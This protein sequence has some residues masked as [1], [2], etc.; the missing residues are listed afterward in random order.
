MRCLLILIGMLIITPVYAQDMQGKSLYEFV[1]EQ[2]RRDAHVKP[3]ELPVERFAAGVY[4]DNPPEFVE[5]DVE[6]K[7]VDIS[8]AQDLQRL[9][10]GKELDSEECRII[11]INLESVAENVS[12]LRDL[13]R[14]LQSIAS[15]Y[16]NP[17]S[18]YPGRKISILS[19]LPSI[20]RIW[21][22]SNEAFANPTI[23]I[24]AAGL[25]YPDSNRD[26]IETKFDE[27]IG[28]LD[29]LRHDGS[30]LGKEDDTEMVA[31][32]W[33]YKDG[34]KYIERL[35]GNC[36]S[37][38]PSPSDLMLLKKR[39]CD[40][41]NRLK[42][43]HQLIIGPYSGTLSQAKF[44]IFPSHKDENNNLIFWVRT[45]DIGMEWYFPIEPVLPRLYTDAY[46]QCMDH[47]NSPGDCANEN[48]IVR[49]GKYPEVVPEPK[50]GD[51]ICSHPFSNG[52]YLCRP[53]EDADCA[54]D[55]INGRPPE[56]IL[57]TG[58]KP[59]QFRDIIGKSPSGPDMC[60]IGG[61]RTN[62]LAVKNNVR[63]TPEEQSGPTGVDPK[64]EPTECSSCAVDFM[65]DDAC[66][67]GSTR[68]GG[69]T[70]PR[71]NEGVILICLPKDE[72]PRGMPYLMI[73]ELVH[74]QQLCNLDIQSTRA[75]I[76]SRE[77][78][79]AIEREA[80][81]AQCRAYAQDGVLERAGV[82]ID[83]CASAGA[84]GSCSAWAPAGEPAC[85]TNE[86]DRDTFKN[87]LL[88]GEKMIEDGELGANFPKTCED[89]V[90]N[91]DPRAKAQLASLPLACNPGCIAEYENTIGNNLCFT[92][93]CLEQSLEEHRLI[94][95]RMPLTS[96]DEAFPWDACPV[97][98]PQ[99]G[100]FF[101][102]PALS[103][104]HFPA[105]NPARLYEELDRALC[106]INGLPASS[107]PV[108]CAFDPRRRINL[109][110]ATYIGM[111]QS[112][113]EQTDEAQ[114][115]AAG[116]R[117]AASG[118][119][120]RKANEFFFS[121]LTR[122]SKSL[123]EILGVGSTILKD[124]GETKFP[125]VMCPRNIGADACSQFSQ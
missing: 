81:F 55:P 14:D 77:S 115:P 85:S 122:A 116:L 40:I 45:D 62:E 113:L 11:Q 29:E 106:Q 58:C 121:Y 100:K 31:A 98:D 64:I 5:F 124:I 95:G 50:E 21:K 9:C 6:E 88:I 96:K 48:N 70:Y 109:P 99:F 57:L 56:G 63:D 22:S 69:Y 42:E 34:V 23:E 52:G 76:N 8:I 119:G 79:C 30:Q 104:P 114:I 97:S 73:H 80:Y 27:L 111:G 66:G 89:A 93:Q 35:E 37:S 107:P 13:G 94:P 71:N 10:D 72:G 49:G 67:P 16:E 43:I 65:C 53:L 33:R 18:D 25:P 101:T 120:T 4:Y 117:N 60:E 26:Q 47:M 59:E 78:C 75:A 19:R 46:R 83:E 3:V 68:N 87:V 108:L 28:K 36:S 1:R 54:A 102:P 86:L 91:I 12:W 7:H 90:N 61:W 112:L 15:G 118:I 41:E 20:S 51:G 38:E 32:V 125:A 74:A 123:A 24:S 110:V 39:W 105:Y 44:T 82:T 84:N 17:I 103:S 92:G 2:V